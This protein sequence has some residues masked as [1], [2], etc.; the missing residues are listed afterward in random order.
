MPD[1]D[2]KIEPAIVHRPS[3]SGVD[4]PAGR[5]AADIS[6]DDYRVVDMEE[7]E[8]AAPA[9]DAGAPGHR[10]PAGGDE[11]PRRSERAGPSQEKP[12][13]EAAAAVDE[14]SRGEPGRASQR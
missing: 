14:L 1:R 11:P 9:R 3:D 13:R 8:P 10:E 7:D 12:P 2:Q 6:P 5:D 4:L